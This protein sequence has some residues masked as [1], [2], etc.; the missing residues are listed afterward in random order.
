MTQSPD[1]DP[2]D[3]QPHMPPAARSWVDVG[4]MFLCLL[5]ATVFTLTLLLIVPRLEDVF[6]DFGLQLPL[7]TALLLRLSRTVA[8]QPGWLFVIW[9]IAAVPVA[10]SIPLGRVGRRILRGVLYLALAALVAG[11]ALALLTPYLSLINSVS[12]KKAGG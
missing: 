8:A 6:R 9:M 12:G 1:P 4:T 11:L 7:L 2:L 10:I 3:Y 5:M